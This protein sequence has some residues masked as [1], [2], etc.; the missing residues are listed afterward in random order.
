MKKILFILIGLIS[1]GFAAKAE[2]KIKYDKALKYLK[3]NNY[4][5]IVTGYEDYKE[6]FEI[7]DDVMEC[8]DIIRKRMEEQGY[9]ETWIDVDWRTYEGCELELVTYLYFIKFS[10]IAINDDGE[11]KIQEEQAFWIELTNKSI[12]TSNSC[13]KIIT[14][15]NIP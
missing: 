12:G 15:S 1:F 14:N 3:D 6:V 7:K 5:V 10:Q 8:V 2:Y 4:K 9:I 11:D 13:K